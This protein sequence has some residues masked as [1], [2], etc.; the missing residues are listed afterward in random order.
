MPVIV[1]CLTFIFVA[2]GAAHMF[3]SLT[4]IIRLEHNKRFLKTNR[5]KTVHFVFGLL[6]L[7]G[8]TIIITATVIVMRYLLGCVKL[9]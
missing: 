3:E 8:C 7:I 4:R 6:F 9:T 5:N 1:R 2:F